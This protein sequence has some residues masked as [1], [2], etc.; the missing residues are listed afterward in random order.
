MS[1]RFEGRRALVTGGSR[2]IGREVVRQLAREG[3]DVAIGYVAREQE[4][5]S[6]RAEAAGLGVR[7][8]T[9][10]GDVANRADIER[11]LGHTVTALGGVDILVH[12]A[13]IAFPSPIDALTEAD[14]DL[15]VDTNLK[16][17]FLLAQG[18][19][20][21]MRERRWGRLVFL[22][23]VAAQVGGV[24]GPHYAASKAGLHGL[25]HY[26]AAH[27]ARE[28]ITSNAIA[29]ALIDTEMVRRNPN[30][31]ADL[32]P[33]GR[34]GEPE[35]VASV[36]LTILANGYITGQVINVNGGWYAT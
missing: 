12:S 16:S 11:M 8:L 13:G 35:E 34:F 26:Y 4:A 30:A 29:P 18:V 7:A 36:I 9:V 32:I 20:P 6:V 5:E 1:K 27:L 14:W 28:G 3:A 23:S 19:L 31:R 17:A 33:V 21:G 25:M 2:G 15:T 10:A 24:V 22:S